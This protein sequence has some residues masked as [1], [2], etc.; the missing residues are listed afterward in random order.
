ME[1]PLWFGVCNLGHIA[2][3]FGLSSPLG[4]KKHMV[5]SASM[6]AARLEVGLGL[7]TPI[8]MH[9]PCPDSPSHLSMN[10]SFPERRAG[11]LPGLSR[12]ALNRTLAGMENSPGNGAYVISSFQWGGYGAGASKVARL[13]LRPSSSC[14]LQLSQ[15]CGSQPLVPS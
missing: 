7:P 10:S 15:T 3:L 1:V 14:C 6:F 13:L 8:P 4:I 12:V 9:L 11:S 2:S 5:T